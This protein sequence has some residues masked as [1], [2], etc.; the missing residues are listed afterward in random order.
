MRL[1]QCLFSIQTLI[2]ILSQLQRK[3]REIPKY[4]LCPDPAFLSS[5]MSDSPLFCGL[6]PFFSSFIAFQPY[7]FYLHCCY[8]LGISSYLRHSLKTQVMFCLLATFSLN[9]SVA[10]ALHIQFILLNAA[11]TFFLKGGGKGHSDPDGIFYPTVNIHQAL[12]SFLVV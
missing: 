10:P 2:L 1:V 9:P 6:A 7:F 5:L 12:S 4:S 8:L 11:R 3:G